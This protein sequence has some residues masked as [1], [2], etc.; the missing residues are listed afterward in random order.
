MFSYRLRSFVV[1]QTLS[2]YHLEQIIIIIIIVIDSI[3]ISSLYCYYYKFQVSIFSWVDRTK[4]CDFKLASCFS[5][6]GGEVLPSCSGFLS[7]HLNKI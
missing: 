2:A 7:K 5:K 4:K 6:L 1:Y 3:I